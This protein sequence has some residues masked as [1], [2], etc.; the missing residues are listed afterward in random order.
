MG[1]YSDVVITLYEADFET[2]VKRASEEETDAFDLIKY[3]TL[4]E[5]K[6]N[7]LVSLFW[8]SV[9]W[10]EDFNDVEFIMSFIRGDDVQYQFRRI[11]EKS[12][13]IEEESNDEDWTLGEVTCVEC[14][15]STEFA[16]DEVDTMSSV[17]KILQKKYVIDAD[18]DIEEV[19]EEDLLNVIST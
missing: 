16:G 18:D 19:S 3:A 11:G 13:D 1:Y 17:E 5:D 8:R 4:Y 2:L 7:N 12:G 14:Y 15:I 10:Y 9:K 6:V